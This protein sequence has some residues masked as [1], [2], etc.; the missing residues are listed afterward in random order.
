MYSRIHACTIP[1]YE[2]GEP[3]IKLS[4]PHVAR[5]HENLAIS[6]RA[7]EMQTGLIIV[8]FGVCQHDVLQAHIW[9]IGSS[10]G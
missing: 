5:Y 10:L 9:L 1:L 3:N 6:K 7:L 4:I 2:L 8:Y